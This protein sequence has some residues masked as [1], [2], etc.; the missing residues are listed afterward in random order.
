MVY[1]VSF[2]VLMAFLG[3]CSKYMAP[4]L[5]VTGVR[6]LEETP[7]GLVLEF[8]IDAANRNEVELPLREV[9]YSL[10]LDGREVFRGVRS[11]EAALRRL[12]T[13][14]VRIPAVIPIGEGQPRPTGRQRY[15]LDGTLAYT[16]PGQFAQVLFDIKVRRPRVGFRDEGEVELGGGR[17]SGVGESETGKLA[18]W[19]TGK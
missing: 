11:P 2:L 18:N 7:A 19:Q 12:G 14:T 13:Q 9:R 17:M 4:T 1:R 6:V 16:T 5:D 15:T 8:S 3:G 10:M